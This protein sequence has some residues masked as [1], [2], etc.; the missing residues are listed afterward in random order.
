MHLWVLL[1]VVWCSLEFCVCV[2]L[3]ILILCLHLVS[4][5]CFIFIFSEYVGYFLK[6]VFLCFGILVNVWLLCD[7]CF[8]E[9]LCLCL[10]CWL[11]A[12]PVG[13]ALFRVFVIG[14]VLCF[15]CF[16]F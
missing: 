13:R 1:G 7:V 8:F 6:S 16:L 15:V 11:W 4:V 5:L 14:F 12:R 10:L 3:G 2:W 9:V